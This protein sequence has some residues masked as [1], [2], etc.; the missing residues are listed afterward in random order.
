MSV[1]S[2]LLFAERQ[3]N[4]GNPQGA[5]EP[6][7]RVLA[8]DPDQAHAHAYL[9]MCLHDTDKPS[10]AEG[11]IETALKLAPEDGFIRYTAGAIALLQRR[12]A[13]AE[14]HL[15]AALRLS[16]WEP[17]VYRFLARLYDE[18]GRDRLALPTLRDGLKVAPTHPGLKADIGLHL[19][20]SGQLEE[21]ERMAAEALAIN[22]ESSDALVLRGQI[23]LRRGDAAGARE[24]ALLALRNDATH[25]GALHLVCAAKFR[26]NPLLGLWWLYAAW[27]A[28]IGRGLPTGM[29][30]VSG[31]ALRVFLFGMI[32]ALDSGLG[33]L[34]IA[35]WLVFVAYTWTAAGLFKRALRREIESVQL[36]TGF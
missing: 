13:S 20:Q 26:R 6:L 18:T 22:P 32:T 17:R 10:D 11:E 25:H 30:I 27:I 3:I 33:R 34:A 14:D 19:V 21:A 4:L 7:R 12:Y 28:R 36:R 9:A 2:D 16:P 35:G 29:I 5:I 23:F 1:Q 24:H 31:I 8:A 15:D